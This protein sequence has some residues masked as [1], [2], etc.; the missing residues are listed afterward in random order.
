MTTCILRNIVRDSNEVYMKYYKSSQSLLIITDVDRMSLLISDLPIAY[1][2]LTNFCR[3]KIKYDRYNFYLQFSFT[4]CA[5]SR[6]FYFEE[7]F[8]IFIKTRILKILYKKFLFVV[9][10]F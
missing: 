10:L 3:A 6:L 5:S 2:N 9:F 7:I 8:F 4:N 1:I